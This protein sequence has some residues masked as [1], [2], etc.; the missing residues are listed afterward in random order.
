MNTRVRE[1]GWLAVWC[2]A[3]APCARAAQDVESVVGLAREAEAAL[4][5]GDTA[6]T[7]ELSS[8]AIEL[9]PAYAPGWRGAGSA[10]GMSGVGC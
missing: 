3:L 8:R 7:L 5:A 6:K 2:L 4:A 10:R 1:C 9:D